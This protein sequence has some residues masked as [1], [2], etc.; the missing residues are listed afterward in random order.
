MQGGR[1]PLLCLYREFPGIILCAAAGVFDM[2]K[3]LWNGDG[4][5]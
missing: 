2:G 4:A 1:E 5:V 3:G